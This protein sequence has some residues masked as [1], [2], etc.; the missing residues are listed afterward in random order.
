MSNCV[1]VEFRLMSSVASNRC[2]FKTFLSLGKRKESH[3]ARS[4]EYG[5]CYNWAVPFLAKNCYTRREVRAGALSWCRIQSP[6]RHFSVSCAD[7][8][9]K[10]HCMSTALRCRRSQCCGGISVCYASAGTIKV[11]LILLMHGANIEDVSCN[12]CYRQL[13]LS[14]RDEPVGLWKRNTLCFFEVQFESA[15]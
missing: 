1:I 13:Y 7:R 8:R 4:G 11:F 3:G 5:G 9:L 12:S 15:C 10:L 6:S 2:P 14:V